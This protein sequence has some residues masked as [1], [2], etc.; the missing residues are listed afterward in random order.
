M[1]CPI[2]FVMLRVVHFQ[3]LRSFGEERFWA[4]DRPILRLP[5]V[6]QPLYPSF[7]LPPFEHWTSFEEFVPILEMEMMK[8]ISCNSHSNSFTTITV[9]RYTQCF[10]QRFN[11]TLTIIP[12]PQALPR[13][14]MSLL[15]GTFY[16]QGS[17]QISL[18]HG[19]QF[20]DMT[21]RIPKL[22]LGK[23]R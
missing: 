12:G 5:N 1:L 8:I 6:R 14:G 23:S 18:L 4:P 13:H 3:V 2:V 16:E 9:G 7:Q 19:C 10:N 15:N 17:T 21:L 22:M 11:S 20:C